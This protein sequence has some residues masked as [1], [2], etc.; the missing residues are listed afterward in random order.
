MFTDLWSRT[1]PLVAI[2]GS[3][4][5]ERVPR[6]G[7][8]KGPAPAAFPN[9]STGPS[10][11]RAAQ[12]TFRG[13]S[14]QARNGVVPGLPAVRPASAKSPVQV[15]Y[16]ST[17]RPTLSFLAMLHAALAAKEGEEAV[18]AA[19][20]AHGCLLAAG[21]PSAAGRCDSPIGDRIRAA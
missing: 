17:P 6:V 19:Y 20:Q 11:A 16:K 2:P 9:P 14:A 12:G 10:C 8:G 5:G 21:P 18:V 13:P 3:R 15:T 4:V 7:G 1:L